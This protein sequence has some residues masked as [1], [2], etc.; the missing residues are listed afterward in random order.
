MSHVKD[1]VITTVLNDN[2]SSQLSAEYKKLE[3]QMLTVCS[4]PRKF[5]LP[6]F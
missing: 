5:R 4:P 3:K 6:V 1:I 2:A